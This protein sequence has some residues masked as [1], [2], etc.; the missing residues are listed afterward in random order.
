M[1]MEVSNACDE[2]MSDERMSGERMS[3]ERCVMRDV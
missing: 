1:R 2:R 3:D